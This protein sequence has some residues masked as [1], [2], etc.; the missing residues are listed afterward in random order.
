MSRIP[1]LA[2]ADYARFVEASAML[3]LA[4][5]VISLLP[6]KLLVR[7][8]GWGSARPAKHERQGLWAAQLALAVERASRRVPWRT[9][10]F[11]RGL[12]T[13]WMLR[14]RGLESILH[15]GIG[16]GEGRLGAH[17]WV[18]LDGRILIGADEAAS[19]ACVAS[20]P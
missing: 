4:A 13:H 12:A 18:S 14:R 15:Y 6:F 10:C 8:L 1:A 17:V 2:T 16:Q 11:H 3:A 19:H 5:V 20:F 7:T 9:V